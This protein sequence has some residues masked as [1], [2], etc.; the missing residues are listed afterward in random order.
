MKHCY[1]SFARSVLI[2]AFDDD[3]REDL[4]QGMRPL[5]MQ[6]E[7]RIDEIKRLAAQIGR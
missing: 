4:P 5:A 2:H 6:R 1:M 7:A 3:N